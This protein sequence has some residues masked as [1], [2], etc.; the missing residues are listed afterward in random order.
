MAV[1]IYLDTNALHGDLLMKGTKARD[2]LDVLKPG[3]I[4]VALSRVVLAEAR[5]NAERQAQTAA[6]DL[7]KAIQQVARKTATSTE[8]LAKH[9]EHTADALLEE[10]KSALAPLLSNA[11]FRMLPWSL[12]HPRELVAQEL[13]ERRPMLKKP[14]GT[15]GMR[16]TLIWLDLLDDLQDRPSSWAVLVSADGGY[17]DNESGALH[18]DLL[19]DL[20]GRGIN[21]ESVSIVR[22]LASA[23]IEAQRMA[24]VI[25]QQQSFASDMFLDYLRSADQLNWTGYFDPSRGWV[26][27]DTFPAAITHI[28]EPVVSSVEVDVI[29]SV[30]TDMP[31]R[32]VGYIYVHVEGWMPTADYF[33]GEHPEIERDGGEV[34]DHYAAVS[35]YRRV[36]VEALAD[37]DQGEITEAEF[38]FA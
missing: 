1:I 31:A 2:F 10:A 32:C 25:T 36:R 12:V 11:A 5:T 20:E 33:S 7:R 19:E 24:K 29:E 3:L 38:T 27:A 4:E 30:S 34:D 18:A 21:H 37:L 17:W 23:K 15:V 6:D 16:D 26:E 28:E 13:A 22:D 9:A 14:A 8:K 35:T